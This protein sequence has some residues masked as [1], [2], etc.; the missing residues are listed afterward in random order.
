MRRGTG[1]AVAAGGLALAVAACGGGTINVGPAA[2]PESV[3]IGAFTQVFS[4][5]LPGNPAQAR[6]VAAFREGEILWSRSEEVSRLVPPV[7]DYVAG[8]ALSKLTSALRADQSEGVVPAGTD[9]LFRTQVVSVHGSQAVLTTC[10]DGTGYRD[11]NPH[12]GRVDTSMTAQ[13][14][15]VYLAETWRM[16]MHGGHWAITNVTVHSLPSP[17]AQ[18]C[19]PALAVSAPRPP[20]MAVLLKDMAAAMRQASSVHLSGTA[21]QNGQKLSLNLSMTRSG[22]VSG[23]VNQDGDEVT[24]LSTGG[25]S[26]V[27][28][29]AAILRS[30]HA[31]AAACK[32]FCGKY[33]KTTTAQ[34]P[35]LGGL[36]MSS[37]MGPMSRS[38]TGT[39]A[40]KVT[41]GGTTVLGGVPVWVIQESGQGTAFVAARGP[42]YLLRVVSSQQSGGTASFTQWNTVRIP[43]PPPASQV[44]NLN[45]LSGD[46]AT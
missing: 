15:Q 7:R 44:V 45:Q 38:I 35:G 12:T 28:V 39:S 32:L 18:R 8:P 1:A 5:A 22:G 24:I 31:P 9:R 2:G 43:G 33:L 17:S 41:F 21:V 20:A 4:D 14:Q 46:Q 25:T 36:S 16:G 34:S 29:N 19:Q 42:H 11:Q 26:Y 27:R 10:D 3:R 30:A 37:L 40:A 23:Q 13:P 6:L